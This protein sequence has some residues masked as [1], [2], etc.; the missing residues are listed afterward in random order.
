[1]RLVMILI[2]SCSFS[3]SASDLG[4]RTFE[5]IAKDKS[6]NE[7][8][9]KEIHD[10][11]F[12]NGKHVQT[13]TSFVCENDNEF[14]KRNL[15]F[16]KSFQQPTYLLVDS[17][18]GLMES[19]TPIGDNVYEIQYQKNHKSK[20][21]SKRLKVPDPAI[22][23]G[24]FNY[25]IKENWEK[26]VDN[27]KLYFNFLSPAF[28]DYFSFQIFKV[29]SNQENMNLVKLRMESRQVFLRLLMKPIFVY[30]D[31]DTKQIVKYEGIS[32]IRDLDGNSY[33]ALLHYPEEGP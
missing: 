13:I 11:I 17:R 22:V 14:A 1:M 8:I 5:G 2:L 26:I 31:T 21:K 24:G 16:S 6:S 33:K 10:E 20:L 28:Q 27:Q 19:I 12:S 4:K 29:D 7:F 25:F 9:Y 15:D 23:D 18:T 30:Y 32:N 3:V